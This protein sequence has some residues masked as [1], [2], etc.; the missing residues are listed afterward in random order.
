RGG[1]AVRRRDQ[2]RVG[3][4][5]QPMRRAIGIL[6]ALAAL[7]PAPAFARTAADPPEGARAEALGG[8]FTA[9]ADDGSSLFWNPAG[10]AR[11]GHQELTSTLGDLYGTGMSDNH[12]GYVFP[13]TDTQAAAFGWRQG[14]QD[15]AGLGYTENTFS[16]G[17][18]YRFGRRLSV[19]AA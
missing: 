13:L 18:A 3:R 7:A 9:L 11:L 16:L 10:L 14:A 8:A 19:G 17:Y 1:G 2:G 12:L 4:G 15:Q 5:G 6:A